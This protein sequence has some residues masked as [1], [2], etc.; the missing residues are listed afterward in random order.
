MDRVTIKNHQQALQEPSVIWL[1]YRNDA[2]DNP[3]AYFV[4]YEG[5]DRY[6]Y[7]CRIRKY[8]S[9]FFAYPAGGKSKVIEIHEKIKDEEGEDSLSKKLFFIDK[10]YEDCEKLDYSSDYYVTSKYAI[11]NYYV[12]SEVMEQ[13]LKSH[14]GLNASQSEY[15]K[16]MKYFDARFLEFINCLT[17]LNLWAIAC[18]LA[19]FSVDFNLLKLKDNPYKIVDISF[20]EIKPKYELDFNF[21]ETEYEKKL[22]EGKKTNSKYEHDYYEYLSK[23]EIIRCNFEQGL[24]EY[25]TNIE[26]YFRGKFIIGFLVRFISSVTQKGK[27][28]IASEF[29]INEKNVMSV[30]TNQ[31]ET[32]IELDNYLK[33]KLT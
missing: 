33:Q 9:E 8:I 2:K 13:I 4:F 31:A 14:F 1:N 16:T 15:V 20:Q 24:D 17:P 18:K 26:C 29:P 3:D 10:D 32:P 11:E 21:F 5:K 30:F 22:E 7:D 19:N 23:K 28:F 25:K 12:T 6:Y 27:G